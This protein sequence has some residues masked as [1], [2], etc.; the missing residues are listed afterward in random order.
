MT[1]KAFVLIETARGKSR[2]VSAA[3]RQVNGIKSAELVTPPYDI[4][5]VAEGD[6]LDDI[7]NL[8]NRQ[9]YSIDG[10]T[11]TVMCPTT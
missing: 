3:I 6:T 9:I 4:I 1:A 8:V 5:A 11:R 2:E 7:G 10:V